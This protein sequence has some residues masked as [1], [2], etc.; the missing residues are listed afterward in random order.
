MLSEKLKVQEKT[1]WF[2]SGCFYKFVYLY[3]NSDHIYREI[4]EHDPYPLIVM[5]NHI[6]GTHPN[7]GNFHNYIQAINLHYIPPNI[8]LKFIR[9]WQ[10]LLERNHKNI[11]LTWEKIVSS[12]PIMQIAI[13][14]YIV[15]KNLILK[16][17]EIMPDKIEDEI[18]KSITINLSI[19]AIKQLS[20]SARSNVF[21]QT[22]GK[23]IRGYNEVMY[24]IQ[25]T[26][27]RIG[28]GS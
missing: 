22:K 1:V 6:S 2:R 10:P 12:W 19:G 17:M 4:G 5:L 3:K 16:P 25:N 26:G 11:R 23:Y 15:K 14:R 13:R 28:W 18:N 8:R 24:G 27:N 9:T 20:D 21:H 7:T